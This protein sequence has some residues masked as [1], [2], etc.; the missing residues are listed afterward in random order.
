MSP[1]LLAG[2][3]L[4]CCVVASFIIAYIIVSLFFTIIRVKYG[5]LAVV[6]T[7]VLSI[8]MVCGS[9]SVFMNQFLPLILKE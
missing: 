9:F 5:W 8:I 2:M 7:T 4:L 3:G 6:I 1:T